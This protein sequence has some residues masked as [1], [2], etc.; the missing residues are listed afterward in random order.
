[1]SAA[2]RTRAYPGISQLLSIAR[3]YDRSNLSLTIPFTFS[4]FF[5]C[6]ACAPFT[7]MITW[8]RTAPSSRAFARKQTRKLVPLPI[9]LAL[10]SYLPCQFPHQLKKLTT[11][12]WVHT[13]SGLHNSY[14]IASIAPSAPLRPTLVSYTSSL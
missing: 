5:P 4:C 14:G 3:R 6:S 8:A 1:M 2:P 11:S 7:G 9:H 13:R 12:L 10:K